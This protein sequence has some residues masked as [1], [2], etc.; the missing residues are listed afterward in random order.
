VNILIESHSLARAKE[1]GTNKNEIMD[2][3]K[4]GKEIGAKY[5]K[6][7][8]FKIYEF[9]KNWLGKYYNQK[10]VKVFYTLKDNT[11]ITITVYVFYGNW[12]N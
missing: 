9:N 3:I 10:M 2:V 1:R 8:K 11:I 6:M 12:E 4:T 5:G 7:A